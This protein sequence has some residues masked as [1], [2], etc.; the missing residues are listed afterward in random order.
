MDELTNSA[1]RALRSFNYRLWA[2]GALVSNIGTW[3]QRTAQD[4]LVLTQLTHGNAT[5]VGIVMSLQFGPVLFLLPWSGFVADHFDRR[6]VLMVTQITMCTLALALGILTVS[7]IVQLWHVYT[8]ALLLGCTTAFDT[9]ARQTF[10]SDLVVESDLPNAVALNSASFNI[11]RTIGPAIG[12]IIIAQIGCGWLF[13]MN[14]ASFIATVTALL[15]L[16][17]KDLIRFEKAEHG[18]ESLT[19]G[20]RY[21]WHHADIKTVFT[22]LFLIGT[23][24]I[25]FPI[26][27]STMAVNAFHAGPSQF[28]ALTSMMATG[29]V[30]GALLSA[31]R[32]RTG[33]KSLCFAAA[34]L[35]I[36]FTFC[37]VMPNYW[38][39]GLMLM[40]VGAATQTFT[41][42]ANSTVQL[43]TLATVRGRVMALF[44]AIAMG[45]TP[46]GAPIVGFVADRFGPRW[47]L[48]V[49]AFFAFI[50]ALI[51][52]YYLCVR[53]GSKK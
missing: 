16:R 9:P 24:C 43:A 23:F 40:I 50:A 51:G 8:F 19:E 14:A 2:S 29:S 27:I 45:G 44:F 28:G 18:R 49:G 32:Q 48:A 11:A 53:K 47:A 26:F 25:N 4:W 17:S 13:I 39:F 36:G 12:G 15:M 41:T 42:T 30:A 31:R 22:M 7:G 37:S 6:K 3:M 5:A 21:A 20:L 1:F 33:V 34:L 35:G 46:I 10:V 38:L 52:T